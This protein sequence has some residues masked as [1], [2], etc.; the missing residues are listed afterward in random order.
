MV[1]DSEG[2]GFALVWYFYADVWSGAGS[3]VLTPTLSPLLPQ[4]DPN[5]HSVEN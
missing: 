3:L 4:S 5:V 2:W 1:Q